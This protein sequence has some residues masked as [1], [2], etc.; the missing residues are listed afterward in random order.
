MKV[1]SKFEKQP[2]VSVGDVVLYEGTYYLCMSVQPP[3]SRLYCVLKSL[4]GRETLSET[5]KSGYH[6]SIDGLNEYLRETYGGNYKVFSRNEYY[7]EVERN[8]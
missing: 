2:F 4:D 6:T 3:Q 1:K 5:L 8:V 7:F